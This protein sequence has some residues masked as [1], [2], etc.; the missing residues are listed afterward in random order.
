[1]NRPIYLTEK[2]IKSK[3][4]Y[5]RQKSSIYFQD[6][7]LYLGSIYPKKSAEKV[8]AICQE[9][10][11]KNLSCLLIESDNSL[12]V[13]I[14]KEDPKFPLKTLP[15]KSI[16][17]GEPLVA[18]ID[19]SKTIQYAVKTIL[20][21]VGYQVVSIM[22]PTEELKILLVRKP[23]LIF[24]DVNMPDISG[25]KLCEKLKRFPQTKD[26]P[27]VMLTGNTGTLDRVRAKLKGANQYITK[28]FT[29]QQ[30]INAVQSLVEVERN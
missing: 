16:P 27:I 30:L 14:E 21:S 1:M 5:S 25:Y 28:P 12:T 6:K 3:I 13:W 4:D 17:S 29:S 15:E 22:K 8:H 11:N 10:V 19:D 7:E 20:Q 2:E 18:C 24:M 26:I 23:I 9:Y